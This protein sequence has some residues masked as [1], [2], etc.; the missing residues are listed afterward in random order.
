M[1]CFADATGEALA[2]L[3]RPGNAGANTLDDH[4][5]VLDAAIG[6]LPEPV[7]AGHRPGDEPATVARGV[8]V[9]VDSAG[10]S[11]P[12]ARACRDRNV[13]FSMVARS[14]RQ[15]H[16]AISRALDDPDRW[17]PAVTQSREIKD[18]ATVAE[19]T[20]LVDLSAWPA[21]TRL[22]VRRRPLH[23]GARTTLF[24][25]RDYR[26]W[27]HYTDNSLGDPMLL[28]ADI[29]APRPCRGPHPTAQNVRAGQISVLRP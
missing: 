5:A 11:T 25:D 3:L 17:L 15:I 13:G 19:V 29:R 14:N 24:P 27:G 28:D 2:G 6:Q 22:I 18:D 23:P 10:C 20:D 1:F 9:R 7:A 12:L 16:T 21:G 26:Y 4:V 8:R